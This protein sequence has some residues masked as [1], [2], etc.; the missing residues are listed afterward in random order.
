MTSLPWIALLCQG[1]RKSQIK[2]FVSLWEAFVHAHS[3]I[4]NHIA[5]SLTLQCGVG[6]DHT[7]KRLWRFLRN[8]RVDEDAFYRN[9]ARFVWTRVQ[10]WPVVPIAIDWTFCEKHDP[11]QTLTASLV[12]RGRGIPILVWSFTKSDFQ[13]YNS[14]SKVEKAFIK[15][16]KEIIPPTSQTIVIL[17]DRGF[18][19]ADLF[20]V[21]SDQGFH[22]LI[23]LRTGVY[24]RTDDVSHR[25]TKDLVAP[26]Q[27]LMWNN[28]LFREDGAIWLKRLVATCLLSQTPEEKD[29]WFLA[30][31]LPWQAERLIELYSK[32]MII[33]EDFR[34]AKSDFHWKHCRIRTLSHYRR[35]L[36]FMVAALV[37]CMLIGMAAERK[38]SLAYKI[39]RCRKGKLDS[40]VTRI[41]LFLLQCDMT[42][43]CYLKLIVRL[44]VPI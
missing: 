27:R 38:P 43:L 21:I 39:I 29:P 13:E 4:L 1:W 23:R 10:H 19:S 44:P 41:G 16:L 25:L 18:A 20:Q 3:A 37:F 15:K 17:A 9:V 40:C 30:S 42:R 8:D 11:W 5:R 26:G 12:I 6:I 31:S 24:V 7:L 35:F 2:T 22:Y 33:E 14:Q 32:R 36:L 28:V 34:T